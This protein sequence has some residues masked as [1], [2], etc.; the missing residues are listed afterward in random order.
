[1]GTLK[2]R[3]VWGEREG[4]KVLDLLNWRCPLCTGVENSA[5]YVSLSSEK[6]LK[7]EFQLESHWVIEGIQ[8][9]ETKLGLK[10]C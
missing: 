8:S 10:K 7:Q 5:E 6:R 4:M 2:E 3:H 1:M 9:N